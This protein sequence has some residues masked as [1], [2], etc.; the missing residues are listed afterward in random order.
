MVH[1][2]PDECRVLGVLIEKA[3]TTQAQYPLS[4]NALA[5]GCSQK[6]NRN[7]VVD[8]TEERALAAIDGL[9]AK[10]LASELMLSGS[11]VSKFK[12]LG[13]ETLQVD[14]AQLVLL[15]ELMLRGPQSLGELRQNASR[16]HAFESL[17]A[18]QA[19]LGQLT[20]R[21]EPLARELPAPPG[22]RA[23]R[24]VQLLCPS[25]HPLE[26]ATGK[27]IEQAAPAADPAQL[28]RLD[29]LEAEVRA[30]R[31]WAEQVALELGVRP[32][33]A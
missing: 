1:L 23:T 22:S 12:H 24:F 11:R 2:E 15:A 18:V 10:K 14:T 13:R 3:L 28:V 16:M 6:N 26:V 4:L 29:R 25:L 33:R 7:P 30:L 9:R 17:E 19:A 27:V 21:P 5:T 32:P 20:G 31:A 8:Y